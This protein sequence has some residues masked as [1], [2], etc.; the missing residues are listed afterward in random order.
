MTTGNTP[1]RLGLGEIDLH[2]Y[3]GTRAQLKDELHAGCLVV[4]KGGEI[5]SILLSAD[6]LS[7]SPPVALELRTQLSHKFG[8]PLKRVAFS[9]TQ[10]HAVA[11]M[12][13]CKA[14][15][16]YI[17][18]GEQLSKAVDDALS[19]LSAA[20][21]C[22][23]EG[24]LDH[25]EIIRRRVRLADVGIF[26][27]WS[28]YEK[29]L[30]GEIDASTQMRSTIS[31]LLKNDVIAL[32]C[33]RSGATVGPHP[34]VPGRL[35]VDA[36]NDDL[37]QGVFFRTPSGEPLG[38]IARCAAHPDFGYPEGFTGG[39]YPASVRTR[40]S[41]SF[42]GNILFLTGPCG[43]QAFP[44]PAISQ[45]EA[46]EGVGDLLL[47][48]LSSASW[49]EIATVDSVTE[50]IQIPLRGDIPADKVEIQHAIERTKKELSS[51]RGRNGTLAELKTLVDRIEALAYW[52]EGLMQG[53]TDLD[54]PD[55][56]N[57]SCVHPF[58]A[59][60]IN[61]TVIIGLP[62]EPV[63]SYSTKLREL[64]PSS[65]NLLV[66]EG[67]NGFLSYVPAAADCPHGGYEVCASPFDEAAEAVI[68]CGAKRLINRIVNA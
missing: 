16:D 24:K 10:N 20:E 4:E 60:S 52:D 25:P 51:V 29:R 32:K 33:P 50:S 5:F 30:S 19:N 14:T 49:E 43:D 39:N 26:T 68:L 12:S 47:S 56:A 41:K 45:E 42:G 13:H 61:N 28:G 37:V 57:G 23:V 38:A 67:G 27:L 22:Y 44:K 59:L 9:A 36:A 66:C 63:G 2:G 58:F 48:K 53:W 40:L 8:I 17:A 65:C 7:V 55:L 21:F 54:L 34:Q 64:S 62:G 18:L 35:P 46:G 1:I 31:G 3:C 6:L 11:E 15:C